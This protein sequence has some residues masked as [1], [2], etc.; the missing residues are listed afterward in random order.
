MKIIV[1]TKYGIFE[2]ANFPEERRMQLVDKL[3][4]I[5]VSINFAF[6]LSDGNEIYFTKEMI[7]DSL[8]ILEKSND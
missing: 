3:N 7:H 5:H 1:H 2:S 8:F 4:N 6:T